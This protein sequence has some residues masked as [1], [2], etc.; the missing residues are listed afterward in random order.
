MDIGLLAL[1]WPPAFKKEF[2]NSAR[3]LLGSKKAHKLGDE[4]KFH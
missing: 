4:A 1:L 3:V 2:I